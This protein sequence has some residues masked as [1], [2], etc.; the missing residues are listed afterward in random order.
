MYPTHWAPRF[1]HPTHWRH[2]VIYFKCTLY[3]EG[4]HLIFIKYHLQADASTV[5]SKDIS[6][7]KMDSDYK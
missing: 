4:W 1:M 7:V 6:R 2:V 5:P 3:L